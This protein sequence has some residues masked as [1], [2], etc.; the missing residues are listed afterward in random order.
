MIFPSFE[1][2][3]FKFASFSRFFCSGSKQNEMFVMASNALFKLLSFLTL[4]LVFVSLISPISSSN[5]WSGMNAS[6][7]LRMLLN[8]KH[9]DKRFRPNFEG[10]TFHL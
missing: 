10:N 4:Q 5:Y 6:H 9:Y 1:T 7:V 8:E 3:R 2:L